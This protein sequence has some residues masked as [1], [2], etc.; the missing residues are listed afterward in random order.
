[1]MANTVAHGGNE[2]K[3]PHGGH[4]NNNR[5]RGG[6]GRGSGGGRFGNPNNPS[7][8]HQCQV[9]GKFGHTI[10]RCWKKIDKNFS[11]PDKSVSAATSS[12][13]LDPAW[14]GNSAATDHITGDLNKLTMREN[15]GGHDQ[16]HTTNGAGIAIQHVGQ[17][18]V[19]TPSHRILLKNALHVPQA[20]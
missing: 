6:F 19:S 7:K 11:G 20:T 2:S 17:S 3:H 18:I 5:G 16:V 15:D 4:N 8:D 14:Y 9:C 1:M 12:Y 10:L 13:Q